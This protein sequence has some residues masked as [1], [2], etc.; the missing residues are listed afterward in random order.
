M[1]RSAIEIGLIQP[2]S[3]FHPLL[4]IIKKIQTLFIFN[5]NRFKSYIK[6][7]VLN[8]QKNKQEL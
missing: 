8:K 7:R 3:K 2:K 6:D 5:Q 4:V 1:L